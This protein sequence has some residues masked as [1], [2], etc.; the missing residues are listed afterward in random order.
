MQEASTPRKS[1]MD[2]PMLLRMPESLAES[3]SIPP[4]CGRMT[5]TGNYSG[6][7]V[8]FE[9]IVSDLLEVR[10]WIAFSETEPIAAYDA[11]R[12]DQAA[13]LRVPH[14]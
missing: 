3:N 13:G 12:S 5:L 1:G 4:I 2:L 7:E 10:F 8:R 6:P 9:D 14:F 11:M